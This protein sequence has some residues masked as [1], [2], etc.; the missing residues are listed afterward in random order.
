M[1]VAQ[2]DHLQ[3]MVLASASLASF[4]FGWILHRTHFCTMGAVSDAVIMGSFDRLRQWALA[5]AVA[6]LG[7]GVMSSAGLISPLKTIYPSQTAPWLSMA[8]GGFLFGWGMVWGSGCGSKSLVRLGAGNLKSLVVLVA[9]GLS[10]LAT[11]KGILAVPRAR[12]L[13][14]VQLDVPQGLFVGQWVSMWLNTDLQQGML[15][16]SVVVCFLLFVWVFKDR[17]FIS[18]RNVFAGFSVGVLVCALWWISGVLGHGLEHP[19]TLEEF[20]LATSSRKM[21]AFSL[22]APLAYGLESLLYFSD[23]TRRLTI[24]MVSVLG[25]CLGSFISAKVQGSFRWEGFSNA[26]DL[27]RHLWGGVLMGIGAVMALGC[28]IGQ[29]LSGMSTLNILS[30]LTTASILLG[31][32]SAL[33]NDLKKAG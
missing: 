15:L 32:I 4:L 7:F 16:S 23:G 14:T 22:T 19:E 31:A 11:L 5:I 3:L 8:L 33:Q 20:F 25:L 13:E 28:S 29:G 30:L 10:A 1:D 24:G 17:S 12:I 2:L 9:M 26:A 21:E 6:A 27:K 18:T